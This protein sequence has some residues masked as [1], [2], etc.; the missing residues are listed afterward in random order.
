MKAIKVQAAKLGI[1]PHVTTLLLRAALL[2]G[3]WLLLYSLV[4]APWGVPDNFLTG[5]VV[6]GTVAFLSLFYAD[7]H[8]IGNDIVING[9]YAVSIANS[10]NGLELI[11]LYAG[12]IILMPQNIGKMTAFICT[13]IIGIT[14]LNIFR[15][16]ALGYMFLHNMYLADVAHHYVF[17]LIIYAVV[18]YGWVLY[19]QKPNDEA[20]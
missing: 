15:C 5:I 1:P 4:I 17:K 10:C 14:V 18:F 2:F 3:T 11:M 16:A 7:A 12:I 19:T 6:K 9:Q 13:G 20:K 8:A